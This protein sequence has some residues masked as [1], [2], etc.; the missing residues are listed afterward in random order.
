[1]LHPSRW[2]LLRRGCFFIVVRVALVEVTQMSSRSLARSSGS[3]VEGSCLVSVSIRASWSVATA[4]GSLR[5]SS[6]RR[7]LR[8]LA[9]F[10]GGA[11]PL[12]I[13]AGGPPIVVY[14]LCASPTWR[15]SSCR[16]LCGWRREGC[17]GHGLCRSSGS[18]WCGGS[19]MGFPGCGVGCEG[20][21]VQRT[22]RLP[23]GIV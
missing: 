18:Q 14:G 1:M 5:S 2:N 20:R 15:R 10:V 6:A 9:G 19:A 16:W 4:V 23:C 17:T 21:V 13:Q 8:I 7:I 22:A 11:M 3:V 12:G